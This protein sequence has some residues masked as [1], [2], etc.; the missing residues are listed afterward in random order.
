MFFGALAT[1][2]LHICCV[3]AIYR[4]NLSNVTLVELLDP[5]K[6]L[7]CGFSPRPPVPDIIAIDDL[8]KMWGGEGMGCGGKIKQKFGFGNPRT[9]V[10]HVVPM[11]LVLD[12]HHPQT[13]SPETR[14]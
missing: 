14:R 1:H 6:G 13:F 5:W 8:S 4:D 2:W 9:D 12:D 3:S 10:S 7:P 11:A